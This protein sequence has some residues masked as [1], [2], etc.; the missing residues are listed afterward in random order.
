MNASDASPGGLER[1]DL[2][3]LAHEVRGALTVIVGMSELLRRDLAP[4]ERT[5]A[6]EGIARAVGRID[7]LV[8]D[9]LGGEL[10]AVRPSQRIDIADLAE[11]VA[12][13]Q[14]TVTGRQVGVFV[15]ARPHVTGS[16]EALERAVGNLIDNGLK[17][18]LESSKVDVGVYE[19]DGDA[20]IEVSDRGPG[21]EPSERGRIFDPFERGEGASAAGTGLGLTVVRSV[22][23]T[24][25]GSVSVDD[26]VGG[27]SV[28]SLRLP[29]AEG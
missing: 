25:G 9:A 20:V 29:V 10:A 13:E 26:R 11:Q 28:F 21:I 2:A 23:E 6:L 22:A 19:R 17:Y 8:E 15:D 5:R 7:R 27:G 24:H 16:R 1:Q 18:S 4:D 12:A 14:R 3:L